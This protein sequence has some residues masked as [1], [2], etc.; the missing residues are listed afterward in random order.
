M[1][2][3]GNKLSEFTHKMNIWA[4]KR[5]EIEKGGFQVPLNECDFTENDADVLRTIEAAYPESYIDAVKTLDISGKTFVYFK[6][7][8]ER[9]S[10]GVYDAL[11]EVALDPDFD[12]P[13]YISFSET[14]EL[15]LD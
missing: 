5:D 6:A 13:V 8:E 4:V 2:T 15:L 14:G 10:D 9:L 1:K 3:L 12:T 7:D 11:N